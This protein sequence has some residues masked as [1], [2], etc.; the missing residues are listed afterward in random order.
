[1]FVISFV[2][3]KPY[4]RYIILQ[5]SGSRNNSLTVQD[6]EITRQFLATNNKV[7]NRGDSFRRRDKSHGLGNNTSLYRGSPTVEIRVQDDFRDN[8]KH[9]KAFRVVF[10]GGSEVGKTSIIEQFMSSEHADVYENNNEDIEE[11]E[12][13]DKKKER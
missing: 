11:E 9:D 1:M 13:D 10:L 2:S 8:V 12:E 4:N 7:I 6:V 5:A 3:T